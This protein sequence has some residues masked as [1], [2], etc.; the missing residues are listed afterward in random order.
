MKLVPLT[1]GKFAK[2]DDADFER[3]SE[4]KWQ[5]VCARGE[6]SVWYARRHVWING[7]RSTEQMHRFLFPEFSITDHIDGDGLNNQ[8][9]NLRECT[10]NQNGQNRKLQDH[11]T[12]FKGV[13]FYKA[14]GTFQANIQSQ[15]RRIFLGYFKTAI[16]AAKAYDAA[17]T[18]YFGSF[19][20]TNQQMEL[21]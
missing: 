7:R 5:V 13:H 12:K 18:K 20:R 19:A 8:K 17:A 6:T 2:V 9:S 21:L 10:R 15:G 3:V 4:F 1:K 14:N 11:S 16:D